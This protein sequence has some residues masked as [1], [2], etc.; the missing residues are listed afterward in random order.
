MASNLLVVNIV[1]AAMLELGTNQ[2]GE[3]KSIQKCKK[4]VRTLILKYLIDLDIIRR[5]RYA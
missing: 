5:G 4:Y 1:I 3:C 2:K